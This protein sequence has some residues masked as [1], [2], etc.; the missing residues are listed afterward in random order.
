[1][2]PDLLSRWKV[3]QASGNMAGSILR[4]PVP[5]P[6]SGR[7]LCLLASLPRTALT[8][9]HTQEETPGAS[10]RSCR[11]PRSTQCQPRA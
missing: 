5:N 10:S 6:I 4:L 2:A 1:M 9:D 8:S 7:P 11:L 3:I